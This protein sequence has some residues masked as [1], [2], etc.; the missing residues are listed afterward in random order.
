[1][2]LRSQRYAVAIAGEISEM[3]LQVKTKEEV[4]SMFRFLWCYLNEMKFS[5]IYEFNRIMSGMNTAPFEV[6][7]MARH[8]AEKHQAEYQLA[9]ETVVESTYMDY[10]MDSTEN[11]DN[12]IYLYD[13]LKK[14]C[15]LSSMRPHKWLS[16]SRKVLD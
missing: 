1:M 7:Y 11:E 16:N 14:I 15:K 5:V 3:H 2:I 6:Q 8:N 9:A 12:T 13:E 4:R 10:T